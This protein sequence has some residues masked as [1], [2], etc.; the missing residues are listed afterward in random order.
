MKKLLTTTL[1]AGATMFVAA[2]SDGRGPVAFYQDKRGNVRIVEKEG[3]AWDLGPACEDQTIYHRVG[4]RN[5]R[6]NVIIPM[7]G[8]KIPADAPCED[9]YEYGNYIMTGH[10]HD[11]ATFNDAHAHDHAKGSSHHHHGHGNSHH[12][13]GHTHASHY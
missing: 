6:G 10:D 8:E 7:P 5:N 3:E 1:I 4:T 11:T 2:C 12:D 13:D 9:R